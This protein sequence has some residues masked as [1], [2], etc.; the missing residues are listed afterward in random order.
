MG[1]HGSGVEAEEEESGCLT[2]Q[3]LETGSVIRWKGGVASV[4][5][6]AQNIM[7]FYIFFGHFFFHR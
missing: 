7:G 5:G 3:I 1:R 2:E 4:V 6:Q